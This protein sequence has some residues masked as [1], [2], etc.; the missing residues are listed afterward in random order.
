MFVVPTSLSTQPHC[1]RISG[2]RNPP[3]ISTSSPRDTMTLPPD[4]TAHKI[5]SIAAALLFTISAASVF[6]SAVNC[7]SMN[8][9]R[10]PRA[11]FSWSYS[12][13][14]YPLAACA[15]ASAAA[16]DKQALPRLE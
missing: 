11:P 14:T 7:S 5:S 4:A 10:E 16:F 13:V 15:A 1:S 9:V 2:T 12:S 3:P 8:P 6:V